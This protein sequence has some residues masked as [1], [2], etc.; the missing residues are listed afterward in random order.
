MSASDKRA[1]LSSRLLKEPRTVPAAA[2]APPIATAANDSSAWPPIDEPHPVSGEVLFDKGTASAEGFRPQHWT[3]GPPK[4]N[5][6]AAQGQ[7]NAATLLSAGSQVVIGT[8]RPS[9]RQLA[10]LAVFVLGCAVL[11]AETCFP[12]LLHDSGKAPAVQTAAAQAPGKPPATTAVA[13]APPAAERL[14]AAPVTGKPAAATEAIQHAAAKDVQATPP[15]PA[16]ERP[17]I[18][19]PPVA[20]HP[21]RAPAETAVP[22]QPKP[23]RVATES[24]AALLG[25]GDAL[26][27]TGD[28]V[29]ARSFYQQAAEAGNARAALMLG[30]TFDPAFLR[31]AQVQGLR[32][33]LAMAYRWYRRA[34][35][36]GDPEAAQ[37]LE[38]LGAK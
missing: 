27:R 8:V 34:Q 22:A 19:A 37:L 15:P 9:P 2:P 23:D 26:L 3:Y 28:I 5:S 36:L 10:R 24:A 35:Q 7:S 18:L 29:S 12:T 11:I 1:S 25:R 17:A 31:Q 32:G 16:S 21:E 14:P 13:A 30:A 6:R 38:A 33:D 20:A 4:T